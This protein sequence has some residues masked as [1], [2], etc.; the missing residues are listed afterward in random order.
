MR[1]PGVP[2]PAPQVHERQLQDA[3]GGSRE[4]SRSSGA[5]PLGLEAVT[6]LAA[7]QSPGAE[8]GEAVSARKC[9]CEH[10]LLLAS[11]SPPPP[12]LLAACPALRS[13]GGGE[14]VPSVAAASRSHG[15][16]AP[17]CGQE[18]KGEQPGP[19]AGVTA[20]LPSPRTAHLGSSA[21]SGWGK[22]VLQR[23]ASPGPESTFP[24]P[25]S[26]RLAVPLS[27]RGPRLADLS[28]P[29]H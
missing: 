10:H 8:T 6:C 25:A 28:P 20:M 22:G 24:P 14:I 4:C 16:G 26:S 5:R 7:P 18:E 17:A 19:G 1:F 9:A 11:P 2:S 27:G 29:L 13:R 21:R 12:K 3:A 15:H 23:R